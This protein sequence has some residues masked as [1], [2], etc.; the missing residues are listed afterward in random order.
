MLQSVVKLKGGLLRA[1]CVKDRV[2]A[3]LC[4]MHLA[5]FHHL[6]PSLFD[7]AS[8]NPGRLVSKVGTRRNFILMLV[9]V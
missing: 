7:P 1:W 5:E 2:L 3:H 6:P 9:S 4:F 8:S